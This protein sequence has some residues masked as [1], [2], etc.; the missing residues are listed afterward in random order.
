LGIGTYIDPKPDDPYYPIATATMD[1]TVF[2][3]VHMF[4]ERGISSVP[5]LDED[6]IVTNI[7]E[8]LD[9]TVSTQNLTEYAP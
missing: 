3:V 9:V 7:Y 5:V 2:A 8:A 6:G 4:S 1:T